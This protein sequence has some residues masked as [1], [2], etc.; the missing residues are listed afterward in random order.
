[1]KA[2]AVESEVSRGAEV[3]AEEVSVGEGAAAD[4]SECGGAGEARES[5]ALKRQ[6]GKGVSEGIHRGEVIS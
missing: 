1:V 5:G 6:R 2:G 4:D 3:S